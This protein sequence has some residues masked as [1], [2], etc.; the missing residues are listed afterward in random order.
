[1]VDSLL[2]ESDF[3]QWW[4]Q[5][6]RLEMDL[7]VSDTLKFLTLDSRSLAKTHIE[8]S[9]FRLQESTHLIGTRT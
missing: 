1:M 6:L 8:L 9:D 2:Q 5:F 7:E 3:A 4:R